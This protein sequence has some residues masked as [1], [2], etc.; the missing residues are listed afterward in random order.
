MKK[1]VLIITGTRAE[2][3]LLKPVMLALLKSRK[4]SPKF[5]VTGMHTLKKFGYT[6]NE[7][8]KDKMPV[9][10][11]V[12]VSEEDDMLES[13]SKE[14]NGTRNYCEKNKVD[15]ILVL[16]DIAPALAG[17]IVGTHLK[18]PVAHINGGDVSGKGPDEFIR[19][20]ITKFS[21]MHFTSCLPNAKRVRSLGEERW[22]ILN[23]GA[24]GLDSLSKLKYLSKKELAKKF[25]LN[26][27]KNWFL[28]VHHPAPLDQTPFLHQV[29]PLLKILAQHNA[30]KLISYPNA[31][32]GNEIF[33]GE[34]EKR[35]DKNQF[36]IFKTFPRIQ[37]LSFLKHSDL[38]IGNSS[39]GFIESG[40]FK[41]PVINIGTRQLG[42]TGSKNII[43]AGYTEK[44]IKSAIN[45]AL[46]PQFKAKA[47]RA[48]SPYN[49]GNTSTK[50]IKILEKNFNLIGTDKLF[51]K[52]PPGS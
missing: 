11:V 33:I 27:G 38:L 6:L 24:T 30:E 17:A 52:P 46:T 48:K 35:R 34:I 49:S 25:N 9:A 5:L 3:G 4:F 36:H 12:P 22:R 40:Y 13:L 45:Y 41:I 1:K 37:Y 29:K 10:A 39:S 19:H 26:P 50:I 43:H 18:I 23:V 51:F 21:H 16:G 28:M 15:L 7:I 32:T 20:A 8:K 44:D 42:R 31:D 2:Y 47:R 14:I